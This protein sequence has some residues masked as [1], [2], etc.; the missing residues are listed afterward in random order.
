MAD[1]NP[2]TALLGGVFIGVS[3]TLLWAGLGRVA[4]ISGIAGGL[5]RR[6]P[7]ETAWRVS[8]LVGLLGAGALLFALSPSGFRVDIQRSAV[9][10]IAAGL[11]VGF[12]TRLGSGCTSGHG[13][14]GM[15]RLSLRSLAAVLTFMVTGALSVFLTRWLSGGV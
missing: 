8:F 5:L 10:M 11:L 12:G 4:G 3:A 9:A 7:G 15:S 14:C 13:V 1:F 2:L 6:D